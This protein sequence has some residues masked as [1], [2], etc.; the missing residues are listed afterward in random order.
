MGPVAWPVPPQTVRS[1]RPRFPVMRRSLLFSIRGDPPSPF[2]LQNLENKAS[3]SR[4]YA[5]SLSLQELR[6]KSREHWSYVGATVPLWNQA[7]LLEASIH[8]VHG[9]AEVRLSKI[10]YY[11]FDNVSC[12]RLADF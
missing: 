2:C 5:R 11:L 4:L 3:N 7:N 1:A 8:K 9:V 10:N 6:A 12:T